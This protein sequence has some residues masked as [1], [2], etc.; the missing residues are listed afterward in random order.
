[1][2][3]ATRWTLAVAGF[4]AAT[5]V[6]AVV[7]YVYLVPND[8]ELASRLAAEAGAQLGVKVS[9]R[10]AHLQLWPRPQLVIEDAATVQPDPI[11]VRRLIAT[12]RVSQLWHRRVVFEN[13]QVIG[14][15]VP[16]LSLHGLRAQPAR[17]TPAVP[18]ETMQFEDLTWVTRYAKEWQFRGSVR[19]GPSWRPQTLQL[20]RSGVQPPVEFH[21]ILDGTDQWKIRWL[22]GGGVAEGRVNLHGGPGGTGQLSGELEFQ[23]IEVF[24]ALDA[25][26]GHSAVR[27]RANGK[28]QISASGR[29]LGELALS[30][31]TRTTFTMPQAT[32]LHVDVD[33]AVRTFGQDHSGQTQLR[34]LTGQM[35]TQ[36]GPDGM[37][38][39]FTHLDARGDTFTAKAE[40]EIAR[41]RVHGEGT[42]DVAG[43]AVGVPLRLD[44]PLSKPHVSLETKGM[45]GTAVGAAV[46]TAILPGAGTLAG[47][48]VGAAIGNLLGRK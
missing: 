44:G 16:Q 48:R 39:R 15:R 43:G 3:R 25:F 37:V 4:F 14:A 20:V 45:A 35:D 46:G 22:M 41:R 13:V 26:K 9:I 21:A 31:H 6:A 5:G 23:D 19:F 1:M 40:G 32:L 12:P 36:A 2:R 24:S 18:V 42:I 27:G 8:Q 34:G 28:T 33:K 29:G 10:T 7:A 11:D 17:R 30:L 38:V 47:A